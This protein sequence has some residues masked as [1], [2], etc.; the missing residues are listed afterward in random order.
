MKKLIDYCAFKKYF[1]K[2]LPKSYK[3][4][5][6]K[7]GPNN[8]Y[9][10]DFNENIYN[11]HG[12]IVSESAN[13]G[14]GLYIET[15]DEALLDD[16]RTWVTEVK[17]NKDQT[18]DITSK[19]YFVMRHIDD[20]NLSKADL[21]LLSRVIARAEKVYISDNKVSF[22]ADEGLESGYL[23]SRESIQFLLE[24]SL[25]RLKTTDKNHF[26]NI[27]DKI[28]NMP[29]KELI[30]VYNQSNGT[31]KKITLTDALDI[32]R[33]Y[34][35]E[36]NKTKI[37]NANKMDYYFE[38]DPNEKRPKCLDDSN[39]YE[40]QKASISEDGLIVWE[41]TPKIIQNAHSSEYAEECKLKGIL[42]CLDLPKDISNEEINQLLQSGL[43][44]EFQ[45]Y[46]SEKVDNGKKNRYYFI[47]RPLV[48]KKQFNFQK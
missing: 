41:R 44:H 12:K 42:P 9:S 39:Q 10:I 23:I 1:R 14:T 4:I 17:E 6:V 31:F 40:M 27:T 25:K 32:P 45:E 28:N 11:R 35:K 22:N 29:F 18:Y 20:L 8:K 3:I 48:E 34:V 46:P 16:A 36:E 24:E 30:D 21:K 38:Y 5:E 13:I 15:S 43:L 37:K 33:T 19:N 7:D 2:A 26:F 47:E